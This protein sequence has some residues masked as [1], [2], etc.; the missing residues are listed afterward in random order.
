M[1]PQQSG[2]MV[3]EECKVST[4]TMSV[5]E[6]NCRG[7]MAVRG[8]IAPVLRDVSLNHVKFVRATM[9][10]FQYD[11]TSGQ[12][13]TVQTRYSTRI[14][15]TFFHT[16]VQLYTM[17]IMSKLLESSTLLRYSIFDLPSFVRSGR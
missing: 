14:S 4:K 11:I 13:L 3:A 6:G 1:R 8:T 7:D 12:D 10:G 16:N 5:V 17:N 2:P 9:L 15:E